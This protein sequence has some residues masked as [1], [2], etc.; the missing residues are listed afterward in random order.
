MATPLVMA[1][2]EGSSTARTVLVD[3][4]GTVIAEA[5]APV[6]WQR[7]RPGWVELDPVALWHT[8]LQTMHDVIAKSGTTPA[9]IVAVGVTSHR[10]TVLV[11]DRATGLPVHNAIVWISNQTDGVVRRWREQGL[12]AEFEERTGLRNDSF[13]S[14][15]KLRWLLDEVPDLRRGAESGRLVC[16]TVDSWLVWNLTGGR[17]HFTDH[18][19]ASRTALFNLETLTWDEELCGWLDI[20][21]RMLPEAVA[22]DSDFGIIDMS[23]L[24][25]VRPGGVPL[26]GVIADQQAGMFGQACFGDGSAKQTFG[27]AGVLTVNS[28]TRPVLVEGLTSSVGWTV[29]NVTNYELE[30]VA[31]HSGQTLHWLRDNFGV[32]SPADRVEDLITAVPDTGGVYLVPAMGGLCAPYWNRSARASIVGLAMDSRREHVV[33]AAVEAMAYQVCDSIEAMRRQGQQITTLKVDGGAASNDVLCQFLADV[34]GIQIDRPVGL[35]RTALGAAY[36][37]G[38][39]RGV[40]SGPV[41]VETAWDLDTSFVPSM[42]PHR[43]EELYVGWRHA[44]EAT[45]SIADQQDHHGAARGGAI[46]DTEKGEQV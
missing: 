45:L 15:A 4:Q 41:D 28:G 18:S 43:R 22:S 38:I 5:R 23:V 27:T 7:P 42:P 30:G 32:L 37:A 44:V 40:W 26:S 2:D 31:F 29:Q 9:D 12:D 10:E 36:I 21:V 34:S 35:E 14:A 6:A 11:W 39:S 24:P 16:G 3:P 33:R 19:C 25:G 1:L 8:Q 20:P 17:S 46:H 13:F